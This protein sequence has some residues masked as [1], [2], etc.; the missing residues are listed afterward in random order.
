MRLQRLFVYLFVHR[1][2]VHVVS[3][4]AGPVAASS[5]RAGPRVWR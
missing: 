3:M 2:V 1:M 4:T 5:T